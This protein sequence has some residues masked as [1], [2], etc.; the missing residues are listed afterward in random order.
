MADVLSVVLLAIG[1]VLGFLAL[2]NVFAKASRLVGVV[3]IFV[4]L[5]GGAGMA[6]IVDFSGLT[7]DARDTQTQGFTG[8][9]FQQSQPPASSSC[10]VNAIT[11]N[12]KSQAD[13]LYRNVENSTG[14]GYLTGTVSANS[15]GAFIDSATTNAGGSGTSYVSMSS[16]PNCG[17]G[18]LVGTVTTGVGFASSRKVYDVEKGVSVSG[19]DFTDKAVHKYEV[20]GGSGDVINILARTSA[21]AEGSS[22]LVNGSVGDEW[23][24][25]NAVS[26]TGTA[27]GTA[28]FLNTSLGARGSINFYIDLKVNGSSSVF[29]AYE[30]PDGVVISYD[31]GTAAKFS[32]NSLSLV[33][34]TAGFSLTKLATCPNDIKD[35]RNTEACWSAPSMKTGVLYRIRGTIV[36][37]NGDIIPSDTAPIIY[38]DDKVFFRDTSG[39]IVYQ[40]FSSSGGTNQGV[41]G[42]ALRF[43]MS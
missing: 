36:S 2:L 6:G 40:S 42:T 4:I 29:G 37:D 17:K 8:G 43:V 10:S 21:L 13:V 30:E 16:I 20:R 32:S 14:I 25:D 24:L 28:Y 5:I 19:Y 22:G 35:N 27:D 23:P 18:E 31:T 11:S 12:G 26:G 9:G 1:I 15:N 39:S 34:D 33:S 41:G 3:S 38:F 7:G